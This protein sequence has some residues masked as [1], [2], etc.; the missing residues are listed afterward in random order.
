MRSGWRRQ[1][2]ALGGDLVM[3]VPDLEEMACCEGRSVSMLSS[4]EQQRGGDRAAAA[5]Q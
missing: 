2:I 1:R 3:P 4:I 5:L